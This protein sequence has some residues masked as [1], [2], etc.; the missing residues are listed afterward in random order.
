MIHDVTNWHT[1]KAK[2]HDVGFLIFSKILIG[3]YLIILNEKQLEHFY[4][5]YLGI[6][7]PF[8]ILNYCYVFLVV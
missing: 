2:L 1:R 8:K 5:E 6:E 7:K 3:P 4:F